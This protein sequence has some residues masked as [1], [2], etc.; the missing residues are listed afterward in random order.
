[1]YLRSQLSAQLRARL[2]Y[3]AAKVERGWQMR[4]GERLHLSGSPASSTSTIH[5]PRDN[6]RSEGVRQF[7]RGSSGDTITSAQLASGTYLSRL[8]NGAADISRPSTADIRSSYLK[9]PPSIRPQTSPVK[10]QQPPRLAPPVDIISGS[11]GNIRRRPNPNESPAISNYNPYPRHRRHH[12]E[13]QFRVSSP[14]YSANGVLVPGTPPLRP[15]QPPSRLHISTPSTSNNIFPKQRT[16]SQNALM[17]Q[18]AI[19][20][21]LFMSSPENSGYHKSSQQR[22]THLSTS[23]EAQME[24]SLN[25]SVLGMQRSGVSDSQ[26]IRK[27]TFREESATSSAR[28]NS[29]VGLEAQA[30][31]EIDRLLDQM[32][33]SESEGERQFSHFGYNEKQPPPFGRPLRGDLPTPSWRQHSS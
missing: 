23:I 29:A 14:S 9:S 18:D 31:D 15:S 4:D 11:G 8:P 27:V 2:S 10:L 13:Q 28:S 30:G 6:I 5:G 32:E 19:E 16:P 25:E 17:E 22:Q 3:A 7:R 33:D 20:T 24:S 12:S 21:L 1:M 26:K